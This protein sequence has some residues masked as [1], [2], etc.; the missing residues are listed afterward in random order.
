LDS[1]KKGKFGDLSVWFNPMSLANILSLSN[2][3]EKYCVTLDTV[4]ENALFVH[5]SEGHTLKFHC[6]PTGLYYSAVSK[7]SYFFCTTRYG[8]TERK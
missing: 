4:V 8:T 1:D 5:I 2:V 3:A 6:G 7:V